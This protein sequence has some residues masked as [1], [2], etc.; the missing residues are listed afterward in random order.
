MY[1][2][3]IYMYT[4]NPLNIVRACLNVYPQIKNSS[5]KSYPIEEAPGT[6]HVD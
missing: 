4:K 6:S 2:I 5:S 1:I 3:Y